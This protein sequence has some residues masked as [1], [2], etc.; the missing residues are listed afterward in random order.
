MQDI[1]LAHAEAQPIMASLEAAGSAAFQAENALR[2]AI[3]MQRLPSEIHSLAM[4]GLRA[5]TCRTINAARSRAIASL[6]R[7]AFRKAMN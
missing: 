1:T 7:L 5:R 2:E 4:E 6:G 3:D